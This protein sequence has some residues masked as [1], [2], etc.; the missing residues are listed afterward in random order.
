MC[1]IM[2]LEDIFSISYILKIFYFIYKKR[3]KILSNINIKSILNIKKIKNTSDVFI[4][5]SFT[6]D[7]LLSTLSHGLRL[8]KWILLDN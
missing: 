4:F 1:L 6:V 5:S 3:L 8:C 2:I 7:Q